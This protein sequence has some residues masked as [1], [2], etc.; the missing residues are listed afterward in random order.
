MQRLNGILLLIALVLTAGILFTGSRTSFARP[1]GTQP[2]PV[3]SVRITFP[4]GYTVRDI[5]ERLADNG[6]AEREA[7]LDAARNAVFDYDFLNPAF[8]GTAVS[9]EQDGE[10]SGE[11]MGSSD[12]QNAQTSENPDT[13]GE[14][15]DI[16]GGET[17][18]N[19]DRSGTVP[20]EISRLEGYLFPDTYDFYQP[21]EPSRALNRFLRNFADK[22]ED[23]QTQLDAAAQR[24]YTLHDILTIAS[25]IEKETDG[26]DQTRIAAVIYN[27]LEGAGDRGGTY[28]YLQIDAALLYALPDHVGPLTMD[29]LQTDSPY[30]LYRHTGLPPTPIANP[31]AQ[32]I[33]AALSP[34]QTEDY[35]YA[36]AKDGH[37]RF[38]S[39]YRDFSAFI[40]SDEYINH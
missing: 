36:L 9:G 31:G 15:P 14:N 3:R 6:V 5:L 1:S 2:E 38:F 27:R 35:Y 23:W 39:S 10:M 37:H 18:G 16:S 13:A 25:L 20:G 4:E 24:G 30:N 19:A 12:G 21:E 40:N 22:L 26:T 33:E 28:G 7:L 32:S 11:Q 17:A 34:A 8:T 29:D